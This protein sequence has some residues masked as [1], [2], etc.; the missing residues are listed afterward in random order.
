MIRTS[1]MTARD[2]ANFLQVKK[3]DASIHPLRVWASPHG[4]MGAFKSD[5][6]QVFYT[7]VLLNDGKTSTIQ[8]FSGPSA[9][10][11]VI[12]SMTVVALAAGAQRLQIFTPTFKSRKG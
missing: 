12:A 6:Q 4:L 1:L 11:S 3:W 2:G 10:Q 9:E 5:K 8:E 7:L